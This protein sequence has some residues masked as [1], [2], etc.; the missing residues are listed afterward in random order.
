M[1]NKVIIFNFILFLFLP[2]SF[3]PV[4]LNLPVT[5]I[6]ALWIIIFVLFF[7]FHFYFLVLF[8]LTMFCVLIFNLLSHNVDPRMIIL[9]LYTY[10]MCGLIESP[11]SLLH[12]LAPGHPCGAIFVRVTTCS[13]SNLAIGKGFHARYVELELLTRGWEGG[14]W[15]KLSSPPFFSNIY[16]LS[17]FSINKIIYI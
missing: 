2:F 8:Q 11:S 10:L 15:H 12:E 3:F 13:L 5:R 14:V 6:L 4:C 9:G 1:F 16:F 17:K 7:I